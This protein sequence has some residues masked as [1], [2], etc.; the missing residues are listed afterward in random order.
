MQPL[1]LTHAGVP[2]PRMLYGTAWKKSDT[3]RLVQLALDLGFRGLDTAAQPKHYDEAAVGSAV[4]AA[5]AS[6]LPRRELYVQT[7]FTAL[8]GQDP[9]RVPYDPKAPLPQQV[10]ESF[11]RSRRNLG[12]DTLD[13]LVLH[14]PLATAAQTLS[15]WQAFEALV[16]AGSVR[17]LGISNCYRPDELAWLW[18]QARIRPAVIQNR[19]HADTGYDRE[20][21]A[22][23]RARDIVYQSF[24]TLTANAAVLANPHVVQ[25]AS[26]RE[27]T[28]AQILFRY[29][30]MQQIVPL[31]GTRSEV[32]MRDDLAVGDFQL[33]DD[34]C[35]AIDAV[36]YGLGSALDTPQ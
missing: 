33:A 31:T 21:R 6:G 27:R 10:S 17:Q 16:D 11:A 1:I 12:V 26:R 14:S 25:I 18:D 13:C 3:Q 24:W 34:E 32:H 20:I 4:K 22:F 23:F 8:S 30:M 36:F 35:A 9:R 7:K 5:L 19:F 29:L 2:V 28:P 15:A